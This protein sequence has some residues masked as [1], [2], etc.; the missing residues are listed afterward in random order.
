MRAGGEEPPQTMVRVLISSHCKYR[1]QRQNV[2]YKKEREEKDIV[3][4]TSIGLRYGIVFKRLERPTFFVIPIHS[5]IH[6]TYEP[7][8]AILALHIVLPFLTHRVW[9]T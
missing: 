3:Y 2:L 5:T 1:I 4:K 7:L 6:L 9:N 8:T